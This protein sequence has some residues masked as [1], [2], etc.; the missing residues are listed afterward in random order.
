MD[1]YISKPIDPQKLQTV[2]ERLLLTEQDS[3]LLQQPSQPV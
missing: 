1:D 3:S 2:L